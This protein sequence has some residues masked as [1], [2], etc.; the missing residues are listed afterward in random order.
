M[1]YSEFC[2][3]LL[4]GNLS[5]GLRNNFLYAVRNNPVVLPRVKGFLRGL[6]LLGLDRC[7]LYIGRLCG[8]GTEKSSSKIA[9]RIFQKRFDLCA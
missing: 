1:T 9:D 3:Q 5:S 2:K 4:I 8:L 7:R 6:R